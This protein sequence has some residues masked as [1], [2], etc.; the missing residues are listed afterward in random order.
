MYTNRVFLIKKIKFSAVDSG[1]LFF[2][3]NDSGAHV[4][5]VFF[6]ACTVKHLGLSHE[7]AK[8]RRTEAQWFFY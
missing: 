7:P 2:F 5:I 8:E 1:G 3:S 4:P 6:F